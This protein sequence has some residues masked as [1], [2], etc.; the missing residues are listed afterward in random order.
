MRLQ[1]L[2]IFG[3]FLFTQQ[4][5]AQEFIDFGGQKTPAEIS[6]K[7][8]NIMSVDD[9][10]SR[11]STLSKQ[12]NEKLSRQTSQLIRSTTPAVPAGP[13]APSPSSSSALSAQVPPPPVP[14]AGAA[15]VVP[16]STS[17]PVNFNNSPTY[18]PPVAAVPPPPTTVQPQQVP[19]VAP[20]S[21]ESQAFTGF[22]TGSTGPQ[23]APSSNSNDNSWNVQY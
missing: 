13:L 5:Y 20:P 21:P 16:S 4:G 22:G 23:P 7:T 17:Q 1:W 3:M 2:W 14:A 18:P 11:V 12:T 9:F 10:K 6:R 19:P 8:T 15:A